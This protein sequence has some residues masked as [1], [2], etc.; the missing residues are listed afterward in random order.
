[1]GRCIMVESSLRP[2]W[3]S[4]AFRVSGS[5]NNLLLLRIR[6]SGIAA[7]RFDAVCC[8]NDL[9]MGQWAGFLGGRREPG[10]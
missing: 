10:L 9:R 6:K 5:E 7:P 2:R 8:V 4:S 1:M 3:R